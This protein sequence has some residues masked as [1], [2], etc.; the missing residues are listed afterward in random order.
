[1]LNYG[2]WQSELIIKNKAGFTISKNDPKK[3][4]Q[5]INDIVNNKSLLKNMANNSKDLSYLFSTNSNFKKL[6]DVIN[7][8]L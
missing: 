7:G 1:M 6:Q 2:G 5:K 4:I 3:A 8:I